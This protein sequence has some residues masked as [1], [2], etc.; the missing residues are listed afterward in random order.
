MAHQ[1]SSG[2]VGFLV[3]VDPNDRPVAGEVSG[4]YVE[5]QNEDDYFTSEE[6]TSCTCSVEVVD[7]EVV[8]A[9][10]DFLE[11]GKSK[12]IPIVFSHEG[13][14]ELRITARQGDRVL[15]DGVEKE[16]NVRPGKT[17]WYQQNLFT[18]PLLVVA[19][20][21]AFFVVLYLVRKSQRVQK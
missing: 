20:A 16:I 2:S 9:R 21:G 3:H 14:Y 17:P 6:L 13:N 11:E 18:L 4:I 5:L 12:V 19:A 10:Y 7:N 8:I 1:F 15:I